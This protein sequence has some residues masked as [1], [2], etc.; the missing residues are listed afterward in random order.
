MT[1]D[2]LQNRPVALV[3]GATRGIGRAIAADLGRT[4]HVLVGGR[5]TDAVDALVQELPSAAPKRRWNTS[6]AGAAM[7][8]STGTGSIT[9]ARGRRRASAETSSRY[10]ASRAVSRGGVSEGR[11]PRAGGWRPVWRR[12]C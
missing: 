11:R 10:G 1:T 7:T 8:P 6:S 5:S 9:G 3:T 2:Q 4:H 12:P